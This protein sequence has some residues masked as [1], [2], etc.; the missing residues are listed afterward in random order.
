MAC[1]IHAV[2]KKK[3]WVSE[4][5][6][7]FFILAN[8]NS[9]VA[10]REQAAPLKCFADCSSSSFVQ[11]C[12]SVYIIKALAC[13]CYSWLLHL[14]LTFSLSPCSISL[15]SPCQSPV[16]NH[17]LGTVGT[18]LKS[19]FVNCS[20]SFTAVIVKE[21]LNSAE[22]IYCKNNKGAPKKQ[23]NSRSVGIMIGKFAIGAIRSSNSKFANLDVL[24]P[25]PIALKCDIPGVTLCCFGVP[26]ICF[27]FF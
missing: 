4:G 16:T 5:K 26:F 2:K 25:M 3:K 17:S 9:R 18:L 1:W 23:C 21:E 27:Y 15:F 13:L 11:G 6:Y 24:W 7:G 20:T 10:H 8:S 19:P 12:C 14:C 22:Y